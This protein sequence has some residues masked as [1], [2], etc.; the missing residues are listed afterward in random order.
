MSYIGFEI[1]PTLNQVWSVWITWTTKNKNE[2]LVTWTTNNKSDD[3]NNNNND[4][5]INNTDIKNKNM[6]IY[7]FAIVNN[8]Y[9]I[10]TP[11]QYI[12]F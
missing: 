9:T 11:I 1:L 6:V 2:L 5:D 7:I 10:I 3:N 4:N 12:I 8:S